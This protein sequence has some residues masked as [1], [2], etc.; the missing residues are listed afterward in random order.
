LAHSLQTVDSLEVILRE[1]AV[2]R[3]RLEE[4]RTARLPYPHTLGD[5]TRFS[6]RLRAHL[7]RGLAQDRPRLVA[8]KVA[9]LLHDAGKAAAQTVEPDGR[10]RFLGHDRDSVRIAG[11]AFRRLRFTK[12][13]VQL[14]ETVVRHHMRPLLLAAQETVSSRAVYRFFR[15]TRDAG[16][17]VLLHAL[18]DCRATYPQDE[19]GEIWPRLVA[20]TARMLAD[21]WERQ[22]ERVDPPS[23]IDGYALMREFELQPGPQIGALLE[24]VRE[25]QIAGEVQTYEQALEL[26]RARLGPLPD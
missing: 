3:G 4:A 17:D 1:L 24:A 25:A 10:I 23:L 7:F 14:A 26:V 6:D 20:L 16:I 22:S 9:A 21:Y 2:V 12:L 18:A 15:D 8:L 11:Q 19:D 5:L 13:E